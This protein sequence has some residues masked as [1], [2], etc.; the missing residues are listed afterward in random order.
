MTDTTAAV[1]GPDNL[2]DLF[3]TA[4]SKFADN[5]LFG[6]KNAARTGYD[7][8]TYRQVAERVDH[9]RGGNEGFE[10]PPGTGDT[11]QRSWHGK[12]T[13]G[14]M[15]LP[16]LREEYC[17]FNFCQQVRS[18]AADQ[19]ATTGKDTQNVVPPSGPSSMVI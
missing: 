13:P 1:N 8:V 11:D 2:A 12:I 17:N 18:S 14:M 4:V 3:E 6:T 7:W 16:F 5:D 10:N 19:L 15:S 9:L